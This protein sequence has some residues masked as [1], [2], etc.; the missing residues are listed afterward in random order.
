[1]R[2]SELDDVG[3]GGHAT[4]SAGTAS[5]RLARLVRLKLF[6]SAGQCRRGRVN[7]RLQCGGVEFG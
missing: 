6:L 2:D 1:L 7:R 4:G 5:G 3:D